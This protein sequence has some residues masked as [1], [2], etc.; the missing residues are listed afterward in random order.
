M[1]LHE[2]FALICKKVLGGL[3]WGFWGGR[4]ESAFLSMPFNWLAEGVGPC[5]RALELGQLCDPRL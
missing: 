3:L 5:R 1:E 2:P 4:Q